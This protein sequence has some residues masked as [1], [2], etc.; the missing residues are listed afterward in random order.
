MLHCIAGLEMVGGYA[1]GAEDG[2]GL[3]A[4]FSLH[5]DRA[6]VDPHDSPWQAPGNVSDADVSSSGDEDGID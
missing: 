3:P 6:W 1:Q 4:I 2:L 5:L